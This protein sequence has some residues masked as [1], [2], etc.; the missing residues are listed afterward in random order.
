[1]NYQNGINKSSIH[2]AGLVSTSSTNQVLTIEVG[3]KAGADNV[4]VPTG[5]KGTIFIEKLA[6]SNNLFSATA[7]QVLAGDSWNV[8]S[9]A[10]WATQETIDTNKFTHSTSVNPNK[11]VVDSNGDYLAIY[12]DGFQSDVGRSNP[13]ISLKVNGVVRAGG[14]VQTHYIRASGG[15]NYSSGVLVYL[16]SGLK[17]NDA[18]TVSTINEATWGTVNDHVPARL[19]LV[20]KQ[21]LPSPVFTI[22]QTSATSPIS[23]SVTFKSD[24]TNVSVTGFTASDISLNDATITNFSGSGHT[25]TF[26]IVP[27]TYPAIINLSVP[28][29]AQFTYGN[30]C[31]SNLSYD[32]ASRQISQTRGTYKICS[33]CQA[34]A[35]S[36][37]CSIPRTRNIINLSSRSWD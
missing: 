34:H 20:K 18:I 4:V 21:S 3:K 10:K 25:Y 8:S 29:G 12:S 36:C 5:E 30:G 28:L 11:V 35:Q 9:E 7:T 22:A 33:T 31:C 23:A 1:M 37:N 14:E 32:N 16:L 19:V 27:T 2:W 17:A 13:K 15:H 26:N 24:D 6:D